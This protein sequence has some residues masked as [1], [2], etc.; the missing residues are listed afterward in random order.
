MAKAFAEAGGKRFVQVG[1]CT[2]YAWGHGL[3]AEE[4]TPDRPASRYGKA[5][6][7]AFRAVE[8]AG[9]GTFDA[10]EARVFFV[11]GP[12]ERPER[13]VPLICRAHLH[14]EVPALGSG[15]PRR[16]LLHAED[17]ARALLALASVE[18]LTGVVNVAAGEATP[19]ADVATK[20]AAI[21][22]A[23]ETGLGRSADRPNDP[24]LLVGTCERLRGTGWVPRIGLDEG[25]SATF[26][27]WR[28][29]ERAG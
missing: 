28:R 1:S 27:W 4:A 29:R 15:R 8:A 2:E 25:L 13:F 26:D 16:D 9:H 17:V 3:C 11:Y 7:A 19:L 5:K 10:I 22:G 6:L 18:G 12:G 21:A 23:R 20:L 14:H 24:D